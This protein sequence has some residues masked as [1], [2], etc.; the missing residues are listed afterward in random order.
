MTFSLDP[1][2]FIYLDLELLLR[3]FC[4]LLITYSSWPESGSSIV[5]SNGF[6]SSIISS[7][8]SR[9]QGLS[10]SAGHS[11]IGDDD[12]DDLRSGAWIGRGRGGMSRPVTSGP[13]AELRETVLRCLTGVSG[14]RTSLRF[15][16]EAISESMAHR[17]LHLLLDQSTHRDWTYVTMSLLNWWRVSFLIYPRSIFFPPLTISLIHFLQ[18]FSLM[19]LL[20]FGKLFRAFSY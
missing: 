16:L 5:S 13:S 2:S 20:K 19:N 12:E 8:G 4:R 14:H 15:G 17:L 9:R 3:G 6:G 11:S 10:A 7:N 18:Y 1:L